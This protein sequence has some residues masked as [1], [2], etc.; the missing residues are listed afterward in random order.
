M[1]EVRVFGSVARGT[2]GLGSDLD[3]LVDLDPASHGLFDL[4]GIGAA[5]EALFGCSVD[6]VAPRFL[7]TPP[8]ERLV[9]EAMRA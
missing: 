2:Q 9:C 8:P 3:V 4:A 7:A 6:V 5:L 1:S